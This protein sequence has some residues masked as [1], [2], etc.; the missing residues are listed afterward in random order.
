[1]AATAKLNWNL[2]VEI[3]GTV[4]SWPPEGREV[5]VSITVTGPGAQDDRFSLANTASTPIWVSATPTTTFQLLC[6][7]SDQTV[8]L[9]IWGTTVA[10][11]HH[12]ELKPNIP[13]LLASDNT[14]AYNAAGGFAGVAQDF[15]RIDAKNSSG[16]TAI[17][18]RLIVA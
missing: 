14:Q 12:V 5:P 15:T 2:R 16:T 1:M 6:I 3:D 18:R 10:S 9:E 4:Y 11:N 8:M 17:I 13:F 7:V